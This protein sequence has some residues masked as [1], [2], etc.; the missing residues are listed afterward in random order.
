MIKRARRSGR[1][2]D[3]LDRGAAAGTPVG[4]EPTPKRPWKKNGR[5]RR[6]RLSVVSD[7]ANPVLYHSNFSLI[8][9]DFRCRG[10]R[11]VKQRCFL[12]FLKIKI[13]KEGE[14]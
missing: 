11:K 2:A 14:N 6:G 4:W 13:K 12:T 7:N 10:E 9:A 3:H 1:A 8:S 5:E